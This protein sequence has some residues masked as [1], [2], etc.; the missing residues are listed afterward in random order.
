[1]IATTVA[2]AASL[3]AD[4]VLARIAVGVS[5]D[6]RG[7]PHFAFGDYGKLTVIGVLVACA[8]WPAVARLCLTPRWLFV[9]LAVAVSAVLLLPDLVI[10]LEGQPGRAVLWLVLMHVAIALITY[11]ALVRLAPVRRRPL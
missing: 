1:M 9:R 5:P 4:W 2:I 10:Y 3:L 6:L 7:Y 11:N 8:G